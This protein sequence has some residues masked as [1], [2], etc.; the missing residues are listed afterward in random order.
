MCIQCNVGNGAK[1]TVIPQ[2]APILV[3]VVLKRMAVVLKRN[4]TACVDKIV[5]KTKAADLRH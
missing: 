1:K 2:K 3:G 4:C 5:N